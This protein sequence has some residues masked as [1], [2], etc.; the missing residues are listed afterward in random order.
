MDD[1]VI[2]SCRLKLQLN[3]FWGRKLC[4]TCLNWLGTKKQRSG[5]I[6]DSEQKVESCLY[7][8]V[9]EPEMFKTDFCVFLWEG[10]SVFRRFS[11]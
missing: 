4:G 2:E 3:R 9:K 8:C 10:N 5:T 7:L 1:T 11:L 6:E